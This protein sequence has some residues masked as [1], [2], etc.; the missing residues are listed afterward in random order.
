[1]ATIML[2]CKPLTLLVYIEF[3]DNRESDSS[4]FDS[5]GYAEDSMQ[6]CMQLHPLNPW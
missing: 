1:M 2:I 6:V 4:R 5:Y 3:S